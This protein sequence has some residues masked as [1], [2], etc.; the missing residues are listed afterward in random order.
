MG[1]VTLLAEKPSQAKAYAAAY[2]VKKRTKHYIEI[3]PNPTFPDGAIITWG[4]GHLV[5][6]NPPEFYHSKYKKWNLENLPI[7][8]K[9]FSYSV[10]PDKRNHYKEVERLLQ[11]ADELIIATD[12]DREGESIAR[13]IF[14]QAH[15][16][17]KPIK[18]LWINSLEKDEIRKGM[19]NLRDGKETYNYFV[20]AQAR[21]ISDWLIGMNLSPLYTLL[22]Q[23]R[24]FSG[25]LGIGRVQSPTVYMIY[26]RQKEIEEFVSK[27]FY[28]IEGNFK[29]GNGTYK[30]MA[31]VKEESK[32][33]VQEFLDKHQ[34]TGK[35]KGIV[36]SVE[37]K[38]K[39]KKSP[40]LHS[41]STLQSVANKKWKYSPSDVLK[42]I[43]H[44]YEK[45]MVTYPRTDCNYITQN[46]FD[47]IKS[48]MEAYQKILGIAFTP[49]TFQPNKRFVDGAKVE[50]LCNRSYE[51][52]S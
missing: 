6:L 4:I 2:K 11:N 22:L 9:T 51:N 3:E 41:L 7:V 28:Q 25:S 37:K 21:Q 46:E 33:V 18:R 27:P 12:I 30:G 8:P 16:T 52:N 42:T 29:S 19:A 40:K 34:I 13:L 20:E 45:R 48:N 44:L 47:Y 14:E 15:V 24:G 1:N 26:M 32:Q 43:Q 35:D 23:Q 10:T 17:N 36:Q 39:R 38:E 5:E 49:K 31:K 50:E